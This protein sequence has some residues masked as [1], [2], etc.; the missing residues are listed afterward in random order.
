MKDKV[1]KI[2]KCNWG[3]ALAVG[4][5]LE[6][7]IVLEHG[8]RALSVG[9]LECDNLALGVWVRWEDN[10]EGSITKSPGRTSKARE[11]RKTEDWE[12]IAEFGLHTVSSFNF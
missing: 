4:R 3:R 6:R 11:V 8:G 12:K 2:Q 7:H 10:W 5:A 1:A 9:T